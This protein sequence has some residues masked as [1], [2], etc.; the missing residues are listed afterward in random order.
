[1]SDGGAKKRHVSTPILVKKSIAGKYS[2]EIKY[3]ETLSPSVL[4][5]FWSLQT[6]CLLKLN[7]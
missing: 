7:M 3:K 2:K 1:M 6:K 5:F 4:V